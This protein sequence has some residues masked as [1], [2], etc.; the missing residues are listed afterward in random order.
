MG[1]ISL[2]FTFGAMKKFSAKSL[3]CFTA[4]C[5]RA[6][7]AADAPLEARF[8]DTGELACLRVGEAVFAT[9]GGN[10]WEAE[11]LINPGASAPGTEQT[12]A[13]APGTEQATALESGWDDGALGAAPGANA[14]ALPYTAQDRVPGAAVPGFLTVAPTNATS[15]AKSEAGG[16]IELSWR[17]IA[18]GEEPAALDAFVTIAPQ[19]DGSQKWSLRF[20]NRS[21]HYALLRTRFPMI[22]RVTRD[23]EGDALLPWQDHGAKLFRRR[24]AQPR[25]VWAHY[26]GYAPPVAAFFIGE[27]G[28]YFAAEDPEAHQKCLV[29]SGE[30]DIYFDTLPE[31]GADGPGYATTIAPLRGDWWEAARR[32][33]A[34]ALRQKWAARG[35]IKDNPAYPRRLCE[36]PLW[37]NIHGR[38]DMASNVLAKAKQT[39]PGFSTGLHWH[40]WQQSAHD[41]NYPEYFPAQPRVKETI[42]FCHSIGQEPMP[43]TNGRLWTVTT[44]GYLLAEPYAAMKTDGSRVVESYASVNN[45][46]KPPLAV[47]CPWTETWR[48]VVQTFTGRILDELGATS[49]FVDQVGAARAFPCYD[50]SHGHP[51]GG[52]AWWREGYARMMEPVRRAYNERGAFLTTEGAGEA[53]LDLFDGFLQVVERTPE[54]VP[55]WSAVYSGYT[56]Y[57]CTPEHTGDDPQS[58]RYQQSREMLWGHPMGWFDTSVLDKPEKCE[59]LARL[60][61]F[62]QANLDAL[63]YGNLLDELRPV[64][65]LPEIAY[66]WKPRFFWR[67][68]A[69]VKHGTTPAVIGNWWRTADGETVLLAANL[70]DKE[71]TFEYE[72]FGDGTRPHETASMTLA[73][74]ELRRIPA[75]Q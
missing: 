9:G 6:A 28:L 20:E 7:F 24:S 37:I 42:D 55:F 47:M 23:G 44:M 53:Y 71:Q 27:T 65:P 18:L 38:S 54:D 10:L 22:R 15:F 72:V 26:L 63:A 35:P 43:Y 66:S 75:I 68:S 14:R 56:T 61:A 8:T 40:L 30:Q 62:R 67:A 31:L 13:F 64:S 3:F 25:P 32:Y 5:A 74:S 69:S 46:T 17:G 4:L 50:P 52:G 60:C 36:I 59:I 33:R 29:E 16:V 39:Y 19:P 51:V 2:C 49:L 48:R 41:I 21:P 45:P 73:P 34:F 11:F 57:F 12:G 70:S 1:I 58:F